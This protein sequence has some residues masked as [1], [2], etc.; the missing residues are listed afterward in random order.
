MR[1]ADELDVSAEHATTIQG[2]GFEILPM[3]EPSA[4]SE[5]ELA[6]FRTHIADELDRDYRQTKGQRRK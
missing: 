4:A 1:S 5:D 6:T 2:R 3:I